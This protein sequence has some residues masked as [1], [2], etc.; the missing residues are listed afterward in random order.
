M[1]RS[2]E[3]SRKFFCRVTKAFIICWWLVLDHYIKRFIWSEKN[4]FNEKAAMWRWVL[5]YFICR[6]FFS[7]PLREKSRCVSSLF[8]IIIYNK[9]SLIYKKW[10]SHIKGGSMSYIEGHFFL[11]HSAKSVD[12]WFAVCSKLLHEKVSLKYKT[13]KYV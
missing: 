2:V 3:M 11:D 4:K 9:V 6:S 7:G 10:D 8:Q 1:W 13:I 5:I 12:N